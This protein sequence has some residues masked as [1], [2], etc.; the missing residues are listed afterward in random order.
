[1]TKKEMK[2]LL[3]EKCNIAWNVFR[4]M[5]DVYGDDNVITKKYRTK[6]ITYDDLYREMFKEEPKYKFNNSAD[7]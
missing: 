5:R 1:M 7:L 6:W 2:K 3:N 4:A